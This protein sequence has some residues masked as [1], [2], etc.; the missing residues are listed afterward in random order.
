MK[1]TVSFPNS[2]TSAGIY[3]LDVAAGKVYFSDGNR[4]GTVSNSYS[5]PFLQSLLWN[6]SDA[7]SLWMLILATFFFFYHFLFSIFSPFWMNI[8]WPKQGSSE[9]WQRQLLTE[10][11][12]VSFIHTPTVVRVLTVLV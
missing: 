8:T 7:V 4:S 10:L 6:V 3:I 12:T 11:S 2:C 9:V 5:C 1:K